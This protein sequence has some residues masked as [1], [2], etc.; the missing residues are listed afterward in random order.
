MEAST[1]LLIADA[2]DVMLPDLAL[3]HIRRERERGRGERREGGREETN[4][5]REGGRE[6]EGGGRNDDDEKQYAS[7]RA[8]KTHTR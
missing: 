3:L 6:R 1:Q 4:G 7:E 2:Y 5:R 8:E